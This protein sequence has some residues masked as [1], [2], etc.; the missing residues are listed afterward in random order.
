MAGGKGP[1]IETT[2]LPGAL[3]EA[4]RKK[5]KGSGGLPDSGVSGVPW[6]RPPPPPPCAPGV[7]ARA[8]WEK[9]TRIGTR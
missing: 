5:R 3:S 6:V 9:H 2:I 4:E 7:F 8:G 1:E